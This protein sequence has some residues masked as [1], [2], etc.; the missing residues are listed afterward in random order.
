MTKTAKLR[1]WPLERALERKTPVRH[2][3]R[4]LFTIRN[5]GWTTEKRARTFSSKEP[6]TLR[7]I[8]RFADDDILM[9]IGANVGIYTLYAAFRGHRV[10]ALEPDALNFALLNLNIMDN[11]Y[12]DLVT[13]YPFSLHRESL[14]AELQM[15]DYSWGGSG[16]SFGRNLDWKGFEFDAAYRQGSAG[17]SVDEFVRQTG[18][19]PAH[20][21]I[22]VDGNEIF[23]LEG[24][25]ATLADPTV[26]SV[27]IE[28]F[29]GHDQYAKCVQLI[30]D[31]GFK[32]IERVAWANA[33]RKN[34]I[35]SENHIFAR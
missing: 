8:D 15:A 3:G 2:E 23:V 22:D 25:A 21:K 31:A 19:C 14:I 12:G 33:V 7:W 34:R 24:S 26:E 10:L 29:D 5:Y 6:E 20:I 30:E 9:D 1:S 32:L 17:I 16:R 13:A 11:G 27:L 18:T 4:T 35:T 28:L